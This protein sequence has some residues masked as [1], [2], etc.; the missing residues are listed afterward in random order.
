[1]APFLAAG[2][3]PRR[4]A[5]HLGRHAGHIRRRFGRVVRVR[6]EFLPASGTIRFRS[7]LARRRLSSSPS[8]TTTCAMRIDDRDVGAGA[9]LQV[10]VGFDVRRAHQRD[11]ARIDDDQFR[12]LAQ[13]A[14]Q[15]RAEHRMAFGRVGADE[16]DGVGLHDRSEFLRTGR[17]THRVL[18]AIARGRMAHARAGIDVVVAES[19]A[20]QLLHQE[21]FLVGTA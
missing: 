8:V 21:G 1:M 19:R 18:Q 10:V 17:L 4:A 3:Q 15:L 12:T 6:D 5:Y 9:Q 14:L 11:L 2:V 16:N 7:A 13:A 20:H